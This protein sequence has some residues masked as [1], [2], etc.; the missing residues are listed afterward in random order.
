ML[1]TLGVGIRGAP[2]CADEV[3]DEQHDADECEA[4]AEREDDDAPEDPEDDQRKRRAEPAHSASVPAAVP[5]KLLRRPR[6]GA[7]AAQH[8]DRA[9]VEDPKRLVERGYDAMAD[10]FAEW[11]RGVTG[12]SRLDRLDELLALLPER[13]DV[14]E[15]GCGA[16]V[17]ST[18]ILAERGNL[19][20]VDI[21]AEQIRRARER[22]PEATFLHA[23]FTDLDLEPASVDAVVAFYVFNHVPQ[24]ELGPLLGRV[25]VWLRPGGYLLASFPT[26]DNPGWR[27]DFLGVE[28]FFAGFAPETNTRLVAEAGLSVV[29]DDRETMVEPDYGEGT[30]Q[31]LLA[32]KP[33]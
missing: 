24:E 4:E 23:D 13:P 22:V 6:A 17:R 18:R 31:W 26:S 28:M 3:R 30:W 12:S 5:S 15:L 1:A 19:T 32:R 21:S 25:A 2:A 20:G 8:Y 14:L 9:V 27:G 33:D 29:R 10:R 16:G 11:Q 7:A